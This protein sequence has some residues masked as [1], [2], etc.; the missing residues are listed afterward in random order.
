[1]ESSHVNLVW[2][3]RVFGSTL[4]CERW[5]VRVRALLCNALIRV[6]MACVRISVYVREYDLFKCDEAKLLIQ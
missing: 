2:M 4:G 6:M 3:S 5:F 1:M